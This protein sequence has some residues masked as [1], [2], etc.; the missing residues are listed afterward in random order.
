M[1]MV[2]DANT[3]FSN[4]LGLEDST[5]IESNSFNNSSHLRNHSLKDNY[6]KHPKW[7]I[8]RMNRPKHLWV[9]FAFCLLMHV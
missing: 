2:G 8:K 3:D 5:N 1:I 9:I 6:N 4:V 7:F